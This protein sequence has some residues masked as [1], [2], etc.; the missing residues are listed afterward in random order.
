M[1]FWG[2]YKSKHLPKKALVRSL[3]R[4]MVGIPVSFPGTLPMS[5]WLY[6]MCDI[7]MGKGVSYMFI[8]NLSP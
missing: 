4:S 2:P 1:N 8:K 5:D 6:G 3:W 7:C